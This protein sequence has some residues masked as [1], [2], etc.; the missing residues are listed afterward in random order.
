MPE[1]LHQY[2]IAATAISYIRKNQIMQPSLDEIARHVNLSP[3]HF[4]RLFTE[5]AGVSPK[6]FLQYTTLN[7]AKKLIRERENSLF[8]IAY[9]TGL[10]GTGRLHDLFIKIESMTPGEF[11]NGGKGLLISYSISHS[12]FGK[13]LIA[14]TEK[15]ICSAG[16][17]DGPVERA[18]NQ[19]REKYPNASIT[20]KKKPIHDRALSIINNPD[21]DPGKITLHLRGTKFQLNVWQALLNIP[22]GELKTYQQVASSIENE[23][24]ARAIGSAIGKNPAAILIPC[25]R[26]IRA[27]GETG[28]YMWGETR[29]QAII[30][31]EAAQ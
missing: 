4:Q 31:W 9:E 8:D 17:I 5:W 28:G 1:Y 27:D 20:E 10:S 15:G 23:N 7:Y 21:H 24:A 14:S 30:G 12:R 2:Q 26:V 6:K 18:V 3:W 29:K 25:H 16:F 22:S 19:L 11:K 13:L